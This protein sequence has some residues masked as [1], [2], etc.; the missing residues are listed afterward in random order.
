MSERF[1]LV[2]LLAVGLSNAAGGE[3]AARIRIEVRAAGYP[4][5][6]ATVVVAAT[7]RVTDQATDAD[8]VAHA[9]TSAGAVR[10]TVAHEGFVPVTVA[11][12]V[13]AGTERAVR[14]D[15]Q[16]ELMIEEEVT[17]VATTRTGRRIE[18]QPLRV[19][20]LDR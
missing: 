9:T 10:V 14:I 18:D 5:E 3:E 19:E 11:V 15:L 4:V 8:G 17:V 1:A 2:A 16:P 12:F 13:A 7:G 20:A 6:R